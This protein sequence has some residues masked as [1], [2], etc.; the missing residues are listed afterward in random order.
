MES[1][2]ENFERIISEIEEIELIDNLSK[3]NIKNDIK[4]IIYDLE[5]YAFKSDN[6]I[7]NNFGNISNFLGNF[8]SI[9][10]GKFIDLKIDKNKLDDYKKMNSLE[11]KINF[12]NDNEIINNKE[13]NEFLKY[14]L[15]K[16]NFNFQTYNEENNFEFNKLILINCIAYIYHI[17]YW[18]FE[19]KSKNIKKW[20]NAKEYY[21]N[22]KDKYIDASIKI[23][24]TFF[25]IPEKNIIVNSES[26]LDLLFTKKIKFVIPNYQRK[27]SWSNDE[28]D[29]L[30]TDLK[31]R[32]K[33]GK[34]HF[35]GNIT[36]SN[37]N[38]ESDIISEIKSN[39]K[40]KIDEKVNFL[41]IVDGQQRFTTITI[42]M[43]ALYEAYLDKNSYD[44]EKI[45][46]NL[47]NFIKN[48]ELPSNRF[49]DKDSNDI[50]RYIWNGDEINKKIFIDLG[51]AKENNIFKIYYY[52]QN[53]FKK[54]SKNELDNIYKGLR[55]LLIGINW[56]KDCDEFELFESINSKGKKLSN[57][58]QF[59]SY[60]ISIADSGIS[61]RN[62]IMISNL[63][64]EYIEDK[65]KIFKEKK[66]DELVN[67]FLDFY[68][69]FYN[70]SFIRNNSE[71]RKFSNFKNI[72]YKKLKKYFNLKENDL[73]NLNLDQFKFVLR[74]LGIF[75]DSYLF[76]KSGEKK[77]WEN[78]Y[79]LKDYY[80]NFYILNSTIFSDILICYFI[81]EKNVEYNDFG[82]I[83]KLNNSIELENILKILENLKIR[84]TIT[85][86]NYKIYWNNFFKEFCEILK[87]ENNISFYDLF[88]KFLFNND[89]IKFPNDVYF[90]NSLKKSIQ[91]KSIIKD[92]ILKIYQEKQKLD[93]SEFELQKFELNSIIESKELDRT[94]DWNI[95]LNN[96]K[97]VKESEFLK[98]GNYFIYNKNQNFKTN[99]KNSYV[100]LINNLKLKNDN[101]SI[102]S[103]GNYEIK[104]INSL[105]SY[106]NKSIK[107]FLSPRTN[108][109]I[110]QLMKIFSIN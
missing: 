95:Y 5:Q 52:I 6:E 63:F 61:E 23:N 9:F 97:D 80:K 50:F 81:N 72:F 13:I 28:I 35:F 30:I 68:T 94:E 31:K 19:F 100:N 77:K 67:G 3:E 104:S 22:E 11:D 109:Y 73:I 89:Y 108:Y 43:R 42:M 49:D 33:D 41:K 105:D 58:D 4:K 1:Y 53:L 15:S 83:I 110:E 40:N 82:G 101:F 34:Y 74:K 79:I 56:T 17:F 55:K 29:D 12:L 64:K 25:D 85:N 24:K 60:L 48:K 54:Y 65:L 7:K 8:L 37:I 106:K 99:L 62:S 88:Y 18:F 98:L 76:A 39:S 90:K 91:E 93:F 27:Y 14:I 21:D 102:N 57:F 10:L 87:G 46:F 32:A 51:K 47:K 2:T 69:N 71:N 96:F 86:F 36:L 44:T 78:H 26:L 16:T 92:I 20:I 70:E 103:S 45:D 75:L 84:L 38:F 66:F 59:K 107:E